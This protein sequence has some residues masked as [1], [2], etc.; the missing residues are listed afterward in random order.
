M[1]RLRDYTGDEREM[2]HGH[3]DENCT[4]LQEDVT[5]NHGVTNQEGQFFFFFFAVG[6]WFDGVKNRRIEVCSEYKER[7]SWIGDPA[8]MVRAVQAHAAGPARTM[9]AGPPIQLCLSLYSF[10]GGKQQGREV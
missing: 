8:H 7:H 1:A 2:S 3:H 4:S 9:C 6:R 10:I 5:S